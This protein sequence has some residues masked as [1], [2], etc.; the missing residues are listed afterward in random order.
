MAPYRRKTPAPAD[1]TTDEEDL[2][3]YDV[4]EE[5][6]EPV[7]T[8]KFAIMEYHKNTPDKYI[9]ALTPTRFRRSKS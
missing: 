3:T 9:R 5:K 1:Y 7:P 4:E 8:D 6:L 2:I